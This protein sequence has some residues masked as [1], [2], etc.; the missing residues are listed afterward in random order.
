MG[1][2]GQRHAPTILT[3]GK[4]PAIHSTGDGVGPRSD[5]EGCGKPRLHRDSIPGPTS[6]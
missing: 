6:P 1:M 4:R 3:L 5:L 2:G